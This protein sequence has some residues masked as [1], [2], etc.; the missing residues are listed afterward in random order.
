[1]SQKE[2]AFFAL[3]EIEGMG[4]YDGGIV[5][6]YIEG[7][8]TVK[9]LVCHEKERIDMY[10]SNG[11]AYELKSSLTDL[12][13]V[14]FLKPFPAIEEFELVNVALG[15]TASSQIFAISVS[16]NG[17]K[18]DASVS[19]PTTMTPAHFAIEEEGTY[20]VLGSTKGELFV[21]ALNRRADSLAIKKY[22]RYYIPHRVS[23]LC[24]TDS[25]NLAI[26]RDVDPLLDIRVSFYQ[27][28]FIQETVL[29]SN[30]FEEITAK[31]TNGPSV[32][33]DVFCS[34]GQLVV[35]GFDWMKIYLLRDDKV[36]NTFQPIELL[37]MRFA[38]VLGIQQRHRELLIHVYFSYETVDK[39]HSSLLATFSFDHRRDF[40]FTSHLRNLEASFIERSTNGLV[41]L[42]NSK[43]IRIFDLEDKS[44]LPSL[45][46][47]GKIKGL[48]EVDDKTFAFCERSLYELRP[49]LKT[50]LI[51]KI[52]HEV[53]EDFT[54]V[55][56]YEID[57]QVV[58]LL[59]G[60][61]QLMLVRCALDLPS[62]QMNIVEWKLSCKFRDFIKCAFVVTQSKSIC[63]VSKIGISM[64]S[65]SFDQSN[66]LVNF[67]TQPLKCSQSGDLL[68]ILFEEE[69]LQIFDLSH[70]SESISKVRFSVKGSDQAS[71]IQLFSDRILLHRRSCPFV[72]VFTLEGEFA[73][74]L[75]IPFPDSSFFH[76]LSH[77]QW[78]CVF[79][80][81]SISIQNGENQESIVPQHGPSRSSY[82]L[83]HRRK[84]ILI[85]YFLSKTLFM[86][87]VFEGKI[88]QLSLNCSAFCQIESVPNTL[89]TIEKN[90]L[91]F[92]LVPKSGDSSFRQKI[93]D[94]IDAI[95]QFGSHF[96]TISYFLNADREK[97][98]VLNIYQVEGFTLK[99]SIPI[100]LS[101]TI[102]TIIA[103][104]AEGTVI[105]LL[106]QMR[107][108]KIHF[109]FPFDSN[110]IFSTL[111][112]ESKIGKIRCD[113]NSLQFAVVFDLSHVKI[114]TLFPIFRSRTEYSHESR[115]VQDRFAFHQTGSKY[116]HGSSISKFD[117]FG[118]RL[119]VCEKDTA[120]LL[121]ESLPSGKYAPLYMRA[122]TFAK[123]KVN[124]CALSK[125]SDTFFAFLANSTFVI[126]KT[127]KL[128][129]VADF[130]EVEQLA[131][132]N[133]SYSF[134]L[135]SDLQTCLSTVNS[136]LFFFK[137]IS[138]KQFGLLLQ[139]ADEVSQGVKG[140]DNVLEETQ[141][142]LKDLRSNE[143][144]GIFN[145]HLFSKSPE[146]QISFRKNVLKEPQT[147]F[148]L[149]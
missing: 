145:L 124:C 19:L 149:E 51:G 20:C 69:V 62:N 57:G 53:L 46:T 37:P 134:S 54:E 108:S 120:L 76:V 87:D 16:K 66:V 11:E 77:N 7:K 98:L 5:L 85:N 93:S 71:D 35:I 15:V 44:E 89:V 130:F 146:G 115:I 114:F 80:N 82:V 13:S 67:E 136:R 123:A 141:N 131:S 33:L 42:G 127:K 90:S 47:C 103:K 58:L 125:A 14:S 65:L 112:F 111:D 25:E 4:F 39:S 6:S 133:L 74:N 40:I 95:T 126:Y 106:N 99:R 56:S 10:T 60:F 43:N 118:K 26:V 21:A 73:R 2:E 68:A 34:K 31:A 102:D 132:I 24:F 140:D 137:K 94:S 121:F 48:F 117:I 147:N 83:A 86:V 27:V 38:K 12:Q 70:P 29:V 78:A 100:T 17:L 138:K 59:T 50:P 113:S 96:F 144:I 36:Q 8:T 109:C 49:Q 143:H 101:E 116:F 52:D 104:E 18:L 22:F 3:K 142:K 148:L 41:V 9:C 91:C 84:K 72:Q 105:L 28:D 122:K 75:A 32:I 30:Y 139:I 92:R 64:M 79:K 23:G 97:K 55:S 61:D 119:L 63:I 107:S 1:M 129:N 88:S 45:N 110:P 81:G 135:I 128:E